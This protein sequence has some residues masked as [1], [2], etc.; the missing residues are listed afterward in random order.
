M[1]NRE[2]INNKKY[3]IIKEKEHVADDWKNVFADSTSISVKQPMTC[4]ECFFPCLDDSN[5]YDITIKSEETD[6][7]K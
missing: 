2:L 1:S 6:K 5:R 7:I 4:K 3:K